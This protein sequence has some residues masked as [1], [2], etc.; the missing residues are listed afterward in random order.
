MTLPISDDLLHSP[1]DE[2]NFNESMYF[3]FYDRTQEI[4]GFLRVGNRVNEGHAEMTM[5]IFLP[6]GGALF[7]FARAPMVDNLAFNTGQMVFTA[8]E[9]LV[10]HRSTYRGTPIQMDDPLVLADPGVAFRS[11]PRA[12][13]ALDLV[14]DATGP[15][16][17][18][19]P[20]GLAHAFALEFPSSEGRKTI[21]DSV[22][23][24][25]HH[26]EQHMRVRGEV[27]VAGKAYQIDGLGMRDHSW[28]PR[29]WATGGH[30]RW[31]TVCLQDGL[32]VM[33]QDLGR[34]DGSRLLTGVVVRGDEMDWMQRL[35]VD[36][37]W[38]GRF[39][40]ALQVRFT[41]ESGERGTLIGTV[42][43]LVPLRHR[44]SQ[45]VTRVGEGL[46]EYRLGDIVG[47]GLS[48]YF[49]SE[50]IAAT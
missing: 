22:A 28:G 23:V 42:K 50:A 32:G 27:V 46:T 20:Y 36:T 7:D 8:L 13:V 35:E 25:Q 6:G 4:G 30:S 38:D 40:K 18:P 34:P 3:N 45:L 11:S 41:T 5:C 21:S 29:T 2:Q 39:H 43:N 9:P 24:I 19:P 48:E 47:Y 15:M 16:F 33:V 10:R 17:E 1:G 14:H 12:E 37:E 26:N 31:L 44:G 49:D